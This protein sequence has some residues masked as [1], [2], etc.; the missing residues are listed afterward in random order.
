MGIP[1]YEVW[2]AFTM[3]SKYHYH[4]SW[5]ETFVNNNE[6]YPWD[7]KINSA[8]WR[9]TTTYDSHQYLGA[10][11]HATPR[12]RLVQKSADL[13]HLIDAVFVDIIQQYSSQKEELMKQT[14]FS[15]ERTKFDTQMRYK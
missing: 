15:Q 7:S 10:E 6:K 8:V 2:K 4:Y 12:G 3:N 1:T 11:L 9:G 13:P 5:D 14:R